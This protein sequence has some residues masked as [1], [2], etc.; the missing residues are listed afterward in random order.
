MASPPDA[1]DD[2]ARA[3]PSPMT[4]WIF[5]HPW[6]LERDGFPNSNV[7]LYATTWAPP[8]SEDGYH[9]QDGEDSAMIVGAKAFPYNNGFEF[10]WWRRNVFDEEERFRSGARS[11]LSRTSPEMDGLYKH[12]MS[13]SAMELHHL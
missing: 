10:R 7:Y 5:E 4:V 3:E 9:S 13:V 12:A 2:E 11:V 1:S 8:I 6:Q